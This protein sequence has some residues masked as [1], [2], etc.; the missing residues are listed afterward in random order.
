MYYLKGIFGYYTNIIVKFGNIMK[1]IILRH[2]EATFANSDRILS[3]AGMRQAAATGTKLSALVKVTKCFSSPKTR[4]VQTAQI[5]C[6][7]LGF[8]GEIEYL[9][10]LT[11][12][13][14]T[15]YLISFIEASCDKSDVILL[16][17]HLPLVEN[18]A[19]E[20]CKKTQIPPQFDTACSLV[21]DFNG[22]IGHFE[23]F[24]SPFKEDVIF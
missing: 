2:G 9:N 15:D 12:S 8:T 4:A 18:L 1:I 10:E 7:Q 3:S 14:N 24:V 23:Q 11:P 19:Y 13:G 6:N 17:S 16:V 5:V 21:I 22:Q 20:L